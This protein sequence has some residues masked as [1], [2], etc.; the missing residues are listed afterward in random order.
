MAYNVIQITCQRYENAMGFVKFFIPLINP[1]IGSILFGI[2]N[3]KNPPL[4]LGIFKLL[5][6]IDSMNP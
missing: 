4:Y 2:I 1:F 3:N 5:K 6:R